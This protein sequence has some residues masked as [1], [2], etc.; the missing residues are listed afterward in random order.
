MTSIQHHTRILQLFFGMLLLIAA[1]PGRAQTIYALSGSDLIAF[2]AAVPSVVTG[3]VSIT[4]IAAGQSLAGLDF[5]P[6][7]G[8]LYALGYNSTTGEARLYTIDRASG[9]A[10]AVGAAA[11]TLSPN[12]GDIGF[13]FNPTVDRIRVTGSNLTN[14]RLHPVTGAIAATDGT[15]AFAA[16]DV[17]AGM[18]PS[19]GTVA[20]TNSY[21]GAATT[22]LY[23]Y[24]TAS[25]LFTTQAP[26]NNG[27][28]NTLGA[29]GIVLS[30]GDPSADLDIYF[31][32]ATSTNR[33]YFVANVDGSNND[34]LYSVN[35][36]NGTT[37]L[38]G[39]IGA[40]RAVSDIA[41]LIER[42]VPATVTGDLL[43]AL[44]SGGSLISFDAAQPGII[45]T[46][47]AVTG[48]ATGQVLSGLD[49]R[50]ATGELYALGYNSMTGEARL[51]TINLMTGAATAI[52]AAPVTL[53]AGLGKV[54]F[55]F[56]PT[57]DRIRV[58][59]SSNANY[60][61]HPVT[62]AIAA[63]DMN[64]AFAAA[65][66]N[67]GMNPSIGTVAYT[68]SF[69]GTTM[70]MLFNYDD[71]LNVFTTQAPPN[72]GT[73]NTLGASGLSQNLADPSSD[74]DIYYDAASGQNR[75]YFVAN[76]GTAIID[77]LYTV[78]LATGAT[79]LVGKIGNGSAI[80]DLA[81]F[82]ATKVTL[83][84]ANFTDTLTAGSASMVVNYPAPMATS[85]C[86]AGGATVTLLSGPASGSIFGAGNTEVCY[87]AKDACGNV[88][89]CCFTITVA[90]GACDVKNAGCLRFEVLSV[91][92]D[93]VGNK[94]YRIRVTNNCSSALNYAA[95]QVPNGVYAVSP[96]N[97][98]TFTAG[99]GRTYQVR[100]PN[101]SPFYS[102]RFKAD[103]T[104]IVG[105][106]SDVFEYSLPQQTDVKYVHLFVRL[107][108]GTGVETYVNTYNCSTQAYNPSV[109][110]NRDNGQD[111]AVTGNMTV[112]PNPT[113]GQIFVDLSAWSGQA[114][115]LTVYNVTGRQVQRTEL[116]AETE[117]TALQLPN[118][119]TG[120]FYYLEMQAADGTKQVQRLVVQR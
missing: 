97:N 54:G 42:N 14:Y 22:T 60:R 90:E 8:Q 11:V 39:A 92:K 9:V 82:I 74:L 4:G 109:S 100:T 16:T 61:L 21:L 99:S 68:N 62:G 24:N 67:A 63:T 29:S 115:S 43:Y 45:R 56:N 30:A 49:F 105:G 51:Y 108:D 111:V 78:N 113:S 34:N 32:A 91:R 55:D 76:T 72:N 10:T 83:S 88:D 48:I 46:L 17:N 98:S 66:V 57:V 15:L 41:V 6:A 96:A 80:T 12:M 64:L 70:T 50:P 52:G 85:T 93:S 117:A 110:E 112:Y 19:V 26:P 119:L 38:I 59:S 7:T 118:N 20:Y 1:V 79:T 104:G 28:L 53:A 13:D 37:T 36:S 27:T 89:T 47:V 73:L 69:A 94:V 2:Q 114:V 102:I 33:A 44:T 35:L 106:Q 116:Q 75:A 120:G 95:F 58:T 87:V 84:C 101:F 5:R 103:N 86:A 65:D 71:S 40:G 3:T 81:A 107:A 31:D 18:N 23:N 77:N 25:N